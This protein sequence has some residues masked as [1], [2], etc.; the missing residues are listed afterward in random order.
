MEKK[1]TIEQKKYKGE[2]SVVSARLPIELIK[3]VD[4][5]AKETGRTRNEILILCLEFA[6]ENIEIKGEK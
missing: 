4:R 3:D 1:L 5:I 2:S 6:L